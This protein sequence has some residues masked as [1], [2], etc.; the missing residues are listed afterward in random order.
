[1]S[2]EPYRATGVGR[3]GTAAAWISAVCALPYLVLKVVW[4]LGM[5]VGISDRSLLQSSGWAAENALMAVIQLTGLLLVLALTRPGARRVPTWLLLFPVWVGIGLLFQVVV[6]AVLVALFSASSQGS[7]GGTAG[8][9]P[10][11]F[12]MVYATFAGQGAALAIAFA[13]HVRARWGR[14]LGARTGEVLARRTA[15]VRSWPEDHLAEM[16]EAVAAMAVAVAL[17]FGYWAAGGSFGLSGSQPHPSVGM[18]ASQV[19]GAGV[20]VVGLLALTGRWGRGTRFWLPAAL[21]WVGSGAMV[22]FDGFNLVINRLFVLF[23]MDTSGPGWSLI[24]TVLVIKVV[25]GVL[26]GTVGALALAAAAKDSHE[27]AGT[28][29]TGVLTTHGADRPVRLLQTLH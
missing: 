19:V 1:M 13:C 23:G 12:V 17:V 29:R 28:A 3:L 18:Q 10:W 2:E 25:I 26:A 14:L 6:G 21:T 24:D 7:S 5:P 4:T 8:I 9:Q 20:A 11:V 15:R 27:P 22:A 16:A